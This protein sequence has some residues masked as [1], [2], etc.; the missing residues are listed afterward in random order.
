MVASY[1]P[2]EILNL[3]LIRKQLQRGNCYLVLQRFNWP[4]IKQGQAFIGTIYDQ[5]AKAKLHLS[6]LTVNEGKILHMETDLE[7]LI[8]LINSPRYYLFLSEF[9]DKNWSENIRKHYHRS[10]TVFLKVNL[11]DWSGSIADVQLYPKFGKL[12]AV[13]TYLD[14]EYEFDAYQMMR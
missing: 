1:N 7:K 11:P 14:T 8:E 13:V 5:H 10:I 2:Y 6:Q 12:K 3:P 4:G 9:S